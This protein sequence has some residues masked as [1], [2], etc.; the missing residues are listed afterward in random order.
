MKKANFT[1]EPINDPSKLSER[2]ILY[3]K[4]S[5]KLLLRFKFTIQIIESILS[6]ESQ[7]FLFI[8][9]VIF[10]KDKENNDVCNDPNILYKRWLIR[11]ISKPD[12][13]TYPTNYIIREIKS[14][15]GTY[16][17]LHTL[18]DLVEKNINYKNKPEILSNWKSEYN[19]GSFLCQVSYE[20]GN[21]YIYKEDFANAEVYFQHC[22]KLLQNNDIYNDK[23]CDVDKTQLNDLLYVCNIFNRPLDDRIYK[24]QKFIDDDLFNE[25]LINVLMEDN[26]SS[27]KLISKEVRSYLVERSK[28][29]PVISIGIAIV[30]ALNNINY[31]NSN[32]KNMSND[33]INMINQQ[34]GK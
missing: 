8:Y 5:Y 18:I 26:N 17:H 30:N 28:D 31:S 10:S 29:Q 13:D 34:N 21:Y 14:L 1:N 12:T 4:L 11:N 19:I 6:I 25:D 27:Q 7:A 16:S 24:V 2:Q 23:F 22:K 3:L 20:I 32:E 9:F 15:D 33:K